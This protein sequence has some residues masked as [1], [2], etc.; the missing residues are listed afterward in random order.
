MDCT[1]KNNNTQEKR[2][3]KFT[4]K[5]NEVNDK[6]KVLGKYQ[7]A[8]IKIEVECLVCGNKWHVVPYSLTIGN[9]CPECRKQKMS[10]MF[11]KDHQKFVE[12]M[13]T[14][15]P[16]IE[17]SGQYVNAHT[18]ILCKCKEHGEWKAQ[19]SHLLN[20][21]GCPKCGDVRTANAKRKSHER[22]SK[23]I[24][25]INDKIKLLDNYESD[26]KKIL[27][28]CLKCQNTWDA[29]PSMLIQ[30]KGCPRCKESKG[31]KTI[32]KLLEGCRIE[33]KSQYR[34][35]ECRNIKPLPFDFAIF[36]KGKLEFL[37]EYDGEQ[38]FRHSKIFGDEGRY[39]RTISNDIIKD[40]FCKTEKIK[41]LRI[42]YDQFNDIQMILEKELK[43]YNLLQSAD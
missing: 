35:K 3:L 30:G 21:T 17:I 26:G 34:I 41:L 39:F 31:E 29:V 12:E 10:L 14:K 5:L 33:H 43:K 32:S 7:T 4:E 25:K 40:E 36:D 9:G 2:A 8:R 38:H 23:E 6:I 19:P 20:G 28:Q 16:L 22:F 13:K 42:R 18:K 24:N 15:N 11:R 27:C 1:T 37:I